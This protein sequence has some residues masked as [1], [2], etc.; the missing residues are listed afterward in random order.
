MKTCEMFHWGGCDG[1]VPFDTLDEC[2]S[3]TCN[4]CDQEPDTGPCKARFIR[5]FFNKRRMVRSPSAS[6]QL[7]YFG[8]LNLKRFF[9]ILTHFCFFFFP[10]NRNAK[11]LFGV[12]VLGM[13]R[14]TLSMIARGLA[15]PNP[16][17]KNCTNRA[18]PMSTDLSSPHWYY[19][20]DK[21]K[22]NVSG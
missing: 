2:E 1:V 13:F 5:Y 22:W 16:V 11:S 15:V 7:N 12:G 10:L 18:F 9:L 17:V 4:P 19:F 20:Q 8:H 3:S 21:E 14:S 6:P